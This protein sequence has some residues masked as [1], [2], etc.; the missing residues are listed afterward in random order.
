MSLLPVR[1]RTGDMWDIADEMDRAINRWGYGWPLTTTVRE[2]L[3]HPTMDIFNLDGEIL[4]ELELP[5]LKDKDVN[6]SV[7]EDHLI[8]EGTRNRSTER[9]EEDAFYSERMYGG[10]HRV[11]HLPASVDADKAKAAFN[12][13]LL[14][15]T[16]PKKERER[17]KKIEVKAS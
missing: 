1:K 6:V 11:V 3:W 4:V 2:G 8:V 5:G 12:D 15:I 14:T 16:L 13:G 10:F 17:G 7:E 9:K